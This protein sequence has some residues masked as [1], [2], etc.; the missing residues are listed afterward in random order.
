MTE[1]RQPGMASPTLETVAAAAGVSRATV[2]R[3]VN[4][5]PKVSP[6]TKRTVDD[7]IA[8]LGYRPNHAARALVNRRTGS[9]ALVVSEPPELVFADPMIGG[10]V[11]AFGQVLGATD[12]QLV[13]MMTQGDAERARLGDYLLGGHVDGVILMS[14]HSDDTLVRD[15]HAARI[16]AVLMGRP[17]SPVQM[18]YVD[19]DSVDGARQAVRHL[20]STG[21]RRIATIAGPQDM[22]AGRDRLLGYRAE[23]GS[24]SELVA[25]GDFTLLS[26]ERA[27]VEL[28]R[29]EPG[30]DGVFAASDLMAAGAMRA[31]RQAGRRVPEDVAM[32][33]YDDL[34]VAL[35]TDPPLTTV[36]QPLE[37][38][39]RA[40]VGL[41]MARIAGGAPGES[42]VLANRLVVRGSA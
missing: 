37:A 31:L 8:L 29:L 14:L 20:A 16:P 40:M 13:L 35:I 2:S 30:I 18:P 15:L 41:L 19:S 7:T 1:E 23:L 33:G 22:C 36:H 24:G 25:Y 10:M 21:R 17:M 5:S 32:V 11:R 26:G 9:V 3:V 42:V 28:L 38:I 39:A 4:G 12:T 27:M 34:E 6:E